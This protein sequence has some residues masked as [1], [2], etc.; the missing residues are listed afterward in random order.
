MVMKTVDTARSD[1]GLSVLLDFSGQE[2]WA[3]EIFFW[4]AGEAC[5]TSVGCHAC[6]HACFSFP[7]SLL[8]VVSFFWVVP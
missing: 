8:T 3:L 2:I 6:M 1:D 4:R 5:S 7:Q